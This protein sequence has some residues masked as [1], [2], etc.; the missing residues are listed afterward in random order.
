MG[1]QDLIL[2]TSG[3]CVKSVTLVMMPFWSFLRF[4]F[5][6]HVG[7]DDQYSVGVKFLGVAETC[8]SVILLDVVS[9]AKSHKI[10]VPWA[11]PIFERDKFLEGP[12]PYFSKP[13]FEL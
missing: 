9:K 11:R 1:F 8:G 10:T 4:L 3:I 7:E 6:D 12:Y 13:T 5:L 2:W